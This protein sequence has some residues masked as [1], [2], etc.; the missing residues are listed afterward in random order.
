VPKR[1]YAVCVKKGKS[2]ETLSW[3][4]FIQ[5]LDWNQVTVLSYPKTLGIA[6]QG[7]HSRLQ[8][9]AQSHLCTSSLSEFTMNLWSRIRSL[10][11]GCASNT[12]IDE[13]DADEVLW[14]QVYAAREDYYR[15]HVGQL[16]KDI[17]KIGHMFGVWPGGGLFV[18]PATA[19][20]EN[21]YAHT[22]FGFSN[23][24]MPAATSASNV[25][26]ERDDQGRVRRTTMRLQPKA[27]A[28]VADG[29]AGYGYEIMILTTGSADWPLWFLQWVANAE[30]LND[31]G[32]LKRVDEYRGLTVEEIR[33]GEDES[34]NVL[35]A[36]A[37][38]PLPVGTELPNGRMDILI[39]T[40]ITDDEM[41][42]SMENGRDALLDRLQ[43]AGVGQISDRSRKSV[44]A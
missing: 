17:L 9:K 24:D 6:S 14:Q 41:Q 28:V 42:W 26:V 4:Q 22:T 29:K 1:S 32:I 8:V 18:I 20:G 21:I 37:R 19:I 33:V 36:K 2:D 3:G 43:Q 15:E 12:P 7:L 16:P 39:A 27:K 25:D 10:L 31:A 35:I 44:L 40:V 13:S 5:M 34:V 11:S 38:P 23:P 30:I